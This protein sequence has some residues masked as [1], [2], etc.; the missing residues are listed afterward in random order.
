[1]VY[2]FNKIPKTPLHT[3][4]IKMS[5]KNS[6]IKIQIF[7]NKTTKNQIDYSIS[8]IYF[9]WYFIKKIKKKESKRIKS[10]AK[11]LKKMKWIY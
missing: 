7:F 1:M 11:M 8:S 3:S 9:S 4:V 6:E 5:L 2:N 10:G